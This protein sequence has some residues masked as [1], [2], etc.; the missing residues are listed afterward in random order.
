M[1]L[2]LPCQLANY[3]VHLTLAFIIRAYGI[4]SSLQWNLRAQWYSNDSSLSTL[5]T[6]SLIRSKMLNRRKFQHYNTQLSVRVS[7]PMTICVHARW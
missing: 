7:P 2:S 5:Y 4:D 3:N 6:S 1:I